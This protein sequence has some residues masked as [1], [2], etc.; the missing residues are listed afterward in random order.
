MSHVGPSSIVGTPTA[1]SFLA[2]ILFNSVISTTDV[3]FL[4]TIDIKNYYLNTPME[5]FEYGIR[6]SE[7]YRSLPISSTKSSSSTTYAQTK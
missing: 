5:R 7:T 1:E 2:K 3:K 6:E 4:M